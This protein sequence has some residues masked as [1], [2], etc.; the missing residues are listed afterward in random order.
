MKLVMLIDEGSLRRV[1][2]AIE[3]VDQVSKK[4]GLERGAHGASRSSLDEAVRQLVASLRASFRIL[5]RQR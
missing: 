1:R 3:R 4:N 5:V 2:S